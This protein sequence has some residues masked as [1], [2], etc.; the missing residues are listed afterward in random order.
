MLVALH[1]LVMAAASFHLA[2]QFRYWLADLPWS[3][4][5]S[6]AGMLIFSAVAAIVFQYC[7]PYR[8]I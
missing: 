5:E 6:W 2:L 4:G 7:G 3:A 8:G 1:D